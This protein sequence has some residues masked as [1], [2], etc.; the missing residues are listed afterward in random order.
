[1]EST[2]RKDQP[3]DDELILF[4]SRYSARLL[5]AGATCIRLEKNVQRIARAYGREVELTIMPR[6]I[7]LSLWEEGRTSTVS[8][9]ASV[10]HN[11]TSFNIN[12]QL[13]KLSWEIADGKTDLATARTKFTDIIN[14]DKQN[15]WLVLLLVTFANASFC[16]FFGGDFTA[17]GLGAL[18]TLVGYY[19]KIML[20]RWGTDVRVMALI[21]SFVSSIFAASDHLFGLGTTPEVA[22]GTSVLYLVPGI[23][24][25]NSFS[26]MLYKHYL[27][28]V[29]RFMD[30]LV[31]TC[32]LSMGLCVGLLLM[33]RGMF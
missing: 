15:P 19:L 13:S 2:K 7:H 23:P 31:F 24:Y 17:M 11:V 30:A 9:I 21:C 10:R 8:S 28:A 4:I 5:G 6:H 3:T 12:T 29:S 18:A 26:D 27:C 20:L 22:L 14:S 16:R 33:G 25:I 1:M 32:C